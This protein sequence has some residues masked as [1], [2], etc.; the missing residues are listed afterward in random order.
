[1]NTLRKDELPWVDVAKDVLDGKYIKALTPSFRESL[2]IGLR[3][4]NHPICQQ[5]LAS[6]QPKKRAGS[7]G[8]GPGPDGLGINT[9]ELHT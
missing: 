5:A 2:I 7:N 3:S 4:I 9:H 8:D 6:L 1:M